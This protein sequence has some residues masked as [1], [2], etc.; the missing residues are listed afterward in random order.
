MKETELAVSHLQRGLDGTTQVRSTARVQR[1]R[2]VSLDEIEPEETS[3]LWSPYYPLGEMTL[4]QGNPGVGKSQLSLDLAMR[5]ATGLPMPL[6]SD[7]RPP[8]NVLLLPGEDHVAKTVRPRL[9]ALGLDLEG[10]R[11]I[12]VAPDLFNF[13]EEGLEMLAGTMAEL[14][15]TLVVVDPLAVY[16]G[17]KVDM[18]RQNQVRYF[19]GPLGR[20]AQEH[21]AAIALVHH[22]KKAQGGKAIHQSIGSVDFVA[23]VRSVVAVYEYESNVVMAH[24]KHNLSV[25]G[26]SLAFT[27]GD[28]GLRWLGPVHITAD[29]LAAGPDEMERV[30]AKG[31]AMSWMAELLREESYPAAE[32]IEQAKQAGHSQRT[33]EDAKRALG[34]ESI[35]EGHHWW[36]YL[37]HSAKT[38][39]HSEGCD[40][41]VLQG[42]QGTQHLSKLN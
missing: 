38:A 29:E 22:A 13:T 7:K 24:A 9:D 33:L 18:N 23:S 37:P 26:D 39:E 31:Q 27:I 25:R 41:A 28:N 30:T 5:V 15:P 42:S 2:T 36:W 4:I 17:A 20:L 19:M 6:L 16:I 34:V 1:L 21:N 11:R 3:W 40:L 10:R 35:K 32:V 12:T 8:A 14:H